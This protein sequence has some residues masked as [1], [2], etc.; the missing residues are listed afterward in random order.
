MGTCSGIQGGLAW[1]L[2]GDPAGAVGVR[3]GGAWGAGCG[4]SP[5]PAHVWPRLVHPCVRLS[6]HA[7]HSADAVMLG[8]TVCCLKSLCW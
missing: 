7:L 5:L 8:S 4:L 3:G 1:V 6:V 2:A